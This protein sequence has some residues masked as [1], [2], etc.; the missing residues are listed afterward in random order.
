MSSDI[1]AQEAELNQLILDGQALTAF[2]TF[3]AED[4]VMQENSDP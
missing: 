2:E 4:V 3:Y 1:A